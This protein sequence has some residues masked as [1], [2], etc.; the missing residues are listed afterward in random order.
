MSILW[1]ILIGFIAGILAKLITPGTNEP[2]GFILNNDI[3]HRRRIRRDL[4]RASFRLVP[5]GRRCRAHWSHGR[6]R[7]CAPDL[8]GSEHPANSSVKQKLEDAPWPRQ[9]HTQI[10]A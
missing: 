2:Q 8:G 10:D 6:R 3:G 5:C 1:T 9:R 4:S 7:D